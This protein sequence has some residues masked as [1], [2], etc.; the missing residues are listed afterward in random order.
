VEHRIAERLQPA[1][2]GFFDD[3]FCERT[4]VGHRAIPGPV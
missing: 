3:G 2:G 1:E 4:A